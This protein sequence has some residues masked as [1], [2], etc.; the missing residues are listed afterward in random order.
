MAVT[1]ESHTGRTRLVLDS[2]ERFRVHTDLLELSSAHLASVLQARGTEVMLLADV[3]VHEA[4]LLLRALYAQP[5]LCKWAAEQSPADLLS[6]A[7][8]AST[9]GCTK[10]CNTVDSVVTTM[11]K[12]PMSCKPEKSRLRAGHWLMPQQVLWRYLQS[13]ACGLK[14]LQSVLADQIVEL[15]YV[16][17]LNHGH[18]SAA[19]P[20]GT[21]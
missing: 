8:I 1:Q 17:M 14:G 16:G 2:G 4:R 12:T 6:L 15:C 9:L 19:S 13:H 3:S 7:Q 11:V 21:L 5:C 10:M 20:D 18:V